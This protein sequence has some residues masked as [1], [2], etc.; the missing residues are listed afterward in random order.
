MTKQTQTFTIRK[1]AFHGVSRQWC[2]DAE[3][4]DGKVFK[5]WCH[6]FRTRKALVAHINA[7]CDGAF[8]NASIV[9]GGEDK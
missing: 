6:G 5:N 8:P 9:M 3:T 4:S 7:V 2:C 1:D